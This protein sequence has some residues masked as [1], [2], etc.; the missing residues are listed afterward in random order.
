M[1]T[2]KVKNQ[3]NVATDSD[4]W[5]DFY[6]NPNPVPTTAGSLWYNVSQIDPLRGISWLVRGLAPGEERTLTS[7]EQSYY[8]DY[9]AW[10][11]YFETPGTH[12]LY[13]YVDSWN[14]SDP[15]GGVD[16]TNESN[17]RSGPVRISVGEASLLTSMMPHNEHEVSVDDFPA[18]PLPTERP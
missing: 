9:T 14:G 12:D 4:F 13:I 16:E 3:G 6:I 5:V 2:V 7:T 18:R 10:W 17:N 11:G 15:N 8:Q 1:I